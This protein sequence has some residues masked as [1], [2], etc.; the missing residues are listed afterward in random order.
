[1]KRLRREEGQTVVTLVLFLFVIVGMLGAVLDVGAW[2]RADRQLQSVADAAALAGAQELPGNA[3]TATA[4]AV[5]YAGKNGGTLSAGNVAVTTD[6]VSN[7]TIKVT[8][9]DSAPTVFTKL[10]GIDSVSIGASAKARAAAIGEAKYV[11]PIAVDIKH[12]LLQCS[13]EPCFDQQTT[14][15]LTKTGPGAFRLLNLDDTKGGTGQKILADWILNGYN[16]YLPLDWYFQDAGAKFNSSEV[17][18]AL[19]A[20]LGDELLFP[21]YDQVIGGGS[22]L[23]Y[24]VVGWVAF[25]VTGFKGRGSSGEIDGYFTEV[26]WDGLAS[27]NP[28][29]PSFGARTISLI[30]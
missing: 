16:D 28:S 12:P 29:A 1:M 13:P 5:A 15:D 21:I 3:G 18:E 6:Q 19:N 2:F 26:T 9:S 10:L 8:V 7:D 20:R 27:T 23:E 11:A 30:E 17:K 4:Q 14:L 25:V 22:N 24:H